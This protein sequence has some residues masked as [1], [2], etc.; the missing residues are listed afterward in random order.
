MGRNAVMPKPRVWYSD[1]TKIIPVGLGVFTFCAAVVGFFVKTARTEDQVSL[2][3]ERLDKQEATVQA[4]DQ[5]IDET[6][7]QYQLIQ[8][9]LGVVVESLKELKQRK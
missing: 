8:Q 7:V 6:A 3:D 1:P 9:Q 4:Q 5:Q 2:L